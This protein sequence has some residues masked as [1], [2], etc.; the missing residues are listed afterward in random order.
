MRG[1]VGLVFPG[2]A[3][4]RLVG[5]AL[6][7]AV[8]LFL[9]VRGVAIAWRGWGFMNPSEA[10]E[11]PMWLVDPHPHPVRLLLATPL[12]ILMG[13]FAALACFLLW[14]RQPRGARIEWD[15]EGITEF[16]GEGVRTA[17]RWADARRSG[18][19][20]VVKR[21][22]GGRYHGGS[23]EQISDSKGRRITRSMSSWTTPLFVYRRRAEGAEIPIQRNL[24]QGDGIVDDGVARHPR[25]AV[26]PMRAGYGVACFGV[27]VMTEFERGVA[28]NGLVLVVAGLLIG[29]RALRPLAELRRIAARERLMAGA[30]PVEII[31]A[32]SGRIVVRDPS[33]REALFD[34]SPLH[35]DDALLHTRRGPAFL[36]FTPPSEVDQGAYRGGRVTVEAH[37]I[38]LAG[39]RKARADLR[40]AVLA[41]LVVRLLI[42]L[43]F[44]LGG[45]LM[46]VG[47]DG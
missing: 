29:L 18:V 37:G 34:P 20:I 6:L 15:D 17:I 23:V 16:D 24:P 26:W 32:E 22:G 40:R 46:V 14:L 1:K 7:F 31:G 43:P 10:P 36:D 28:A 41:E 33:G 38:E 5:S 11:L 8:L 47:L 3:Y 2:R 19:D 9:V 42:P 13:V 45:L 25:W 12:P 27:Y 21:K 35:H 39:N 44:L 30:T 4:A